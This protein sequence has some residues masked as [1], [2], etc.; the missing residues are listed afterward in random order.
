MAPVNPNQHLSQKFDEE[1]GNLRNEVMKM[2]VLVDQQIQ[3]AVNALSSVD[4]DEAQAVVRNDHYLS[5]KE[6]QI[7]VVT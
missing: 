3:R 7:G 5:I 1:M 2:G 6:A 4:I